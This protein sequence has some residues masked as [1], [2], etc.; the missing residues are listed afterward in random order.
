MAEEMKTLKELAKPLVD[1]LKD[2]YHPHAAI[3]V[4]EERTV[5]VED[6]TSIPNTNCFSDIDALCPVV[7]VQSQVKGRS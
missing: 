6:I 5:V 4:T 3:I 2:N 7:T 1:F